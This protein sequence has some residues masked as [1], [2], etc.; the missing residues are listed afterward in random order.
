MPLPP[1]PAP[2]TAPRRP[3]W[4]SV[5]RVAGW[6]VFTLWSLSVLAWLTL[7]WGILPRI[8][9][10]RPR[11]EQAVGHA[12]GMPVQIGRIEVHSSGWVPALAL[13]EVVLRD[14]RGR[15]ALR[16]P[17]VSAALSVP[18]LMSL[19][20]RF[21]QLLIDGPRVEVRRDLRGHL[22]V[23]GMDLDGEAVGGGGDLADWFFE[24]HEF[25]VRAGVVRWVDELRAAPPLELT[26]V[27]LVVRNQL[28]RHELRLDATPPAGWG[29][30]FTL[31]VQARRPLLAPASDWRRWRGSLHADLP[32]VLVSE[33]RQHV[34]LPF[35]LAQGEGALR[36]WVDFD[37]GL[38]QG[39]TVD[40]ALRDVSV[41]LAAGLQP[42]ALRQVGGRVVVERRSDGVR[43][44]ASGFGFTTAQGAVWP[45]GRMTLAW[46]QRQVLRAA[47][48]A[49]AAAPVTGGAFS[50]ER[51]DLALMAALA[52]RLP[53]G[54]DVRRLLG[55][56]DPRGM[57]AG[58]EANWQGPL[59][60]PSRYGIKG[61]VKGMSIAAAASPVPGGIGRPGW[62]GADLTFSGSERGGQAQLSIAGGSLE[63]PG[64]FDQPV[65][66]LRQF[67]TQLGWRIG[68]A[69]GGDRG[70]VELKLSKARFEN[71]DAH[72]EL[73]ATWRTGAAPGFGKGARLP[74]V[75]D[76]SGRLSRGQATAVARYLPLG[77]PAHARQYVRQAVQAGRVDSADF[78]VK[79][80]LWDFPFVQRS[81]G[82]FRIAGRVRDV[83]LA[84]VPS[85][86]ATATEPAWAS[87]WPAFTGVAGDLVFD[88][89]SMQIQ[90]ASGRLWGIELFDASG[91]IRNLVEQPALEIDGRARGATADLLRYVNA[92]P[93]GEWLSG[94]LEIGRAH[95]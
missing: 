14:P 73:E 36:A 28:Q 29:Q 69:D 71:D 77:I 59:D 78:T 31:M 11:I 17:R 13:S 88:R 75:L 60:S 49:E 80:D 12:M 74:G 40:L 4:R 24:Q 84:Y 1:I 79:G 6:A 82:E 83:T 87:P 32:Q 51:L 86:P 76:L 18:A 38:P 3:V 46:Q 48:L 58:L 22:R 26:D 30:R 55:Q 20:L 52:E 54:A 43:A 62:H 47:D 89:T 64:V 66:G 72:G 90:R 23:A 93:V 92:T 10:W 35:E 27:R 8:D 70:G 5:L 65:V 53:L 91:G 61:E 94:A 21:Q 41:R 25:V 16:L 63:F 42:L 85:T 95:V 15:E 56:L 67:S 81:A 33:L 39:G 7:H 57:V 19:Q 34:D 9:E 45:E 2:S 68:S 50:A 37:H 44:Q